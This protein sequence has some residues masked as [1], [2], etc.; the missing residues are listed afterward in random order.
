M[1][2]SRRTLI[3]V[4]T[5]AAVLIAATPARAAGVGG[6]PWPKPTITYHSGATY[7]FAVREAVRTW[8]RSGVRIRFRRASRRRAQILI[9]VAGP[10]VPPELRGAC[11]G[12]AQLGYVPGSKAIVRIRRGC[13]DD[14]R[15]AKVV[16]HE[17][18]HVLG[19]LHETRRCALMNT[20]GIGTV[21]NRCERS[22]IDLGDVD[23][24]AAAGQASP[25]IHRVRAVIAVAR[26]AW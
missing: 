11:G 25:A 4:A 9:G 8:N 10:P 6:L 20:T 12:F 1:R 7:P 19:L 21:G 14:V 3:L 2:G 16:A 26:G 5:L 23:A 15:T 17:L 22:D 18:G 24:T 13:V